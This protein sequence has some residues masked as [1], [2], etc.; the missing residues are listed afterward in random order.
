MLSSLAGRGSSCASWHE[1]SSIS[2]QESSSS[3]EKPAS[4]HPNHAWLPCLMKISFKLQLDNSN[5]RIY[6]D[7]QSLT[8]STFLK[9]IHF[10]LI[11]TATL[12]N[13]SEFLSSPCQY[14]E[15]KEF[16]FVKKN[17][18]QIQ[19]CNFIFKV[20]NKFSRLPLFRPPTQSSVSKARWAKTLWGHYK[21]TN[22]IC[23]A[24]LLTL[25]C[26]YTV[27]VEKSW[28][29]NL[30][31][32]ARLRKHIEGQRPFLFAAPCGHLSLVTRSVW[33]PEKFGKSVKTTEEE[34]CI[35]TLNRQQV[36]CSSKIIGAFDFISIYTTDIQS[37]DLGHQTFT[38]K[39]SVSLEPK[40]KPNR[41]INMV[42]L[43]YF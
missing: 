39:Q 17:T 21:Y 31:G 43:I 22:S 29:E 27:R 30:W 1:G 32:E 37:P 36:P 26:F 15:Q 8:S 14:L 12:P 13:S 41:R 9:N 25:A 16:I 10:P 28:K 40:R 35:R 20:K 4:S 33:P 24:L 2:R 38:Y 23:C 18:F 6:P 7:F 11:D 19:K 34:K 5:S 3:L 42:N